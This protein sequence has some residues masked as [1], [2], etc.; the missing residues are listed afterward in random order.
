MPL[1]SELEFIHKVQIGNIGNR[2]FINTAVTLF[3]KKKCLNPI[4]LNFPLGAKALNG[5]SG[6]CVYPV[7]FQSAGELFPGATILLNLIELYNTNTFYLITSGILILE[8]LLGLLFSWSGFGGEA[9]NVST[10]S[11]SFVFFW[12]PF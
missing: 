12:S 5:Y 10:N 9:P 4:D 11:F 8:G 3:V 1:L 2:Q 7:A 6:H